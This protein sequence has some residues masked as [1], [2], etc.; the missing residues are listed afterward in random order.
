MGRASRRKKSSPDS[1]PQAA[2]VKPVRLPAYPLDTT[3]WPLFGLITI[4]S[5]VV[6]ARTLCPTIFTTGTGENVT[7]VSALGVPHPPG[8]PL[9]CLLGKLFTYLIPFG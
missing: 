8:F 3:D 9:F 5:L 4:G 6:Y 1:K 2:Q 7:A